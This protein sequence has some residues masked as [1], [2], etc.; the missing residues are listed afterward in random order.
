[1]NELDET[2]A[3]MM[4]EATAKAHVAGQSD[5]VEYL[6]L[7]TFNDSIRAGGVNWLLNLMSEIAAKLNRN[8]LQITIEDESP[9]SFAAG[10]ATLN[11]SLRRFRQG[12][13][14]L[15]VEAGWTRTPN[16]G[17]MRGNVL[18]GARISHFG[19]A[20]HNAELILVN[21]K[22]AATAWFIIDKNGERVLFDENHLN[23]HFQIFLNTI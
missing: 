14:C 21:G 16:D 20:R 6:R 2:W 13:R 18:A 15:S 3:Q 23:K 17:F 9:H 1:M 4:N 8:N 12:V 10:S 22:E 7:K 5:V 11:G 19:I